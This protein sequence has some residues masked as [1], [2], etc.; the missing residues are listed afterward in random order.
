MPTT[1]ADPY[2]MAS[3]RRTGELPPLSTVEAR[4]P[5]DSPI[6]INDGVAHQFAGKLSVTLQND[7]VWVKSTKIPSSRNN[8]LDTVAL[9][10]G[11]MT[12]TVGDN[13]DEPRSLNVHCKE[14]K[15]EIEIKCGDGIL[16]RVSGHDG[17]NLYNDFK[18]IKSESPDGEP[19]TDVIPESQLDRFIAKDFSWAKNTINVH[20][21]SGEVKV[22]T[23]RKVVS[24][25]DP[26][27][28]GVGHQAIQTLLN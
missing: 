16:T 3:F 26:I 8:Q 5:F 25:E 17:I 15:T 21:G 18:A 11:V 7:A 9:Q 2:E 23:G 13:N 28:S 10:R 4:D 27:V 24:G 19:Y 20:R 6:G 14:A 22:S 1:L 12:V